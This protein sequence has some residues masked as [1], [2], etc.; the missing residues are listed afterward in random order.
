MTS[1]PSILSL[2]A[3]RKNYTVGKESKPVLDGV[4]FDV[5]ERELLCI[6]GHSGTGKSTLLRCMA[7]LLPATSGDITLRGV[8]VTGPPS[9]LAVVFQDY[10]RSLLPWMRILDNVTLPLLRT[11]RSSARRRSAGEAALT[12]VGLAGTGH[13]YP[14]QMSGGMQ[15]RVAIAR[16]IAYEPAVL[17]MDEPF[18]SVDAQTRADLEDLTLAI[19]AD[20]GV[21]IVLVTHDIDEAVYLGDRVV[22]LAGQ[23]A[24]IKEEVDVP[25]PHPRDQV[26]TKSDATFV[27]L[28]TRVLTHIR[29]ESHRADDAAATRQ[30]AASR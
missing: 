3:V 1:S 15:Q 20:F 7:G 9:D 6:V 26:T 24:R 12:A 30:P 18:A 28:R 23:P 4:S 16:A 14:W 27:E 17:L 25:L 11:T 13:L 8:P 19:R 2:N 21:T 29:A 10:S 5:R 22:L